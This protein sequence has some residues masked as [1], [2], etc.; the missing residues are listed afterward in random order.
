MFFSTFSQ[1]ILSLFTFLG[2]ELKPFKIAFLIWEQKYHPHRLSCSQVYKFVSFWYIVGFRSTVL[3]IRTSLA[4]CSESNCLA[5]QG[6]DVD[7]HC[8][9]ST[10]LSSVWWWASSL[11]YCEGVHSMIC[12]QGN[13]VCVDFCY[14]S[15][16]SL[17]LR[18][19]C[20]Y[21]ADFS[22]FN[23]DS[24]WQCK[25][26]GLIQRHWAFLLQCDKFDIL[27]TPSAGD[28]PPCL[29]FFHNTT[30]SFPW[31]RVRYFLW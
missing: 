24:D 14:R 18:C 28:H 11:K 2:E 25:P 22:D 29:V 5:S 10:H 27:L 21:F 3:F 31:R 8:L 20:F 16:S 12:L 26:T 7:I 17:D 30:Q 13:S 15:C 4:S 1:V 19:A 9:Y 6:S 23:N